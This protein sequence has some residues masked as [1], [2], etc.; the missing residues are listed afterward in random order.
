MNDKA[1]EAIVK[2]K[3]LQP[4]QNNN[5]LDGCTQLPNVLELLFPRQPSPGKSM[6]PAL[7]VE[8][9]SLDH[10]INHR[11]IWNESIRPQITTI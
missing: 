3:Q 9:C 6:L 1:G 8:V 10:L 2:W 7:I 11:I 5:D 4:M